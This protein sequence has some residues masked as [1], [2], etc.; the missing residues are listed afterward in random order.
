MTT[1]SISPLLPS[2]VSGPFEADATRPQ[3]PYWTDPPSRDRLLRNPN[4]PK[5]SIYQGSAKKYLHMLLKYGDFI[6]LTRTVLSKFSLPN[7][8]RKADG[9]IAESTHMCEGRKGGASQIYTHFLL[10]LD[11][12]PAKPAYVVGSLYLYVCCQQSSPRQQG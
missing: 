6:H 2:C 4:E 7:R 1:V 8:K 9:R 11:C 10:Q 5:H 3:R 12:W